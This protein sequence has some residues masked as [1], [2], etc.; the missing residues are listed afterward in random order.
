MD[1]TGGTHSTFGPLD[2]YVRNY[3]RIVVNLK[4]ATRPYSRA[5]LDF[6]PTQASRYRAR[7]TPTGPATGLPT[8][9]SEEDRHPPVT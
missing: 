7:P 6:H 8:L 1:W 4:I 2:I 9:G 5:R 3:V